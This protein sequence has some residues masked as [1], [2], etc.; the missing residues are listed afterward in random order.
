[1]KGRFLLYTQLIL[2][3]GLVVSC[4]T[5]FQP[6]KVSIA[7]SLIVEGT[8]TNQPGPYSVKMTRTADYSYKSLNLLET[9]A[10]VIISDNL[11]NQETLKEQAPGGTYQTSATGIRGVVGR[12]Y[13][14]TIRTRNGEQYESAPEVLKASPPM[15]R[16]YY[17][18]RYDPQETN[19]G[20]AN[21]WDV[22]VDTKDP[23][24]TGDYYRWEWTHYE[25]TFVCAK[26][27]VFGSPSGYYSGIPCCSN[28]WDIKRCY[29]NCI[30]IMSDVNVNGNSISRQFIQRVPYDASTPYYLE[31]TQQSLSKGIYDFFKSSR[32]QVSNTGGLFDAAPASIGG[33]IHSTSNASLK[34]YGYFGAVGVSEGYILIDRS[35]AVG[36]PVSTADPVIINSLATCVTCANDQYRTPNKPRWWPN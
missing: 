22:Y 36:S 3:V 23:E 2:F 11:G 7:P 32:Q 14:L 19:N 25:F 35:K 28:C 30:N 31:V 34:A 21:G 24:T 1:M 9:G 6:D 18:Y 10:T 12:T 17:E 13:K 26:V 20:R 27:Y 16:I 5:E 33:N 8:I 29:I 15:D 4:V